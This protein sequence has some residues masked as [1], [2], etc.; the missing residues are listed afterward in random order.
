[1][2]IVPQGQTYIIICDGTNVYSAS[3]SGGGGGGGSSLTLANGA[4]ASPSLNFV[5]DTTTGLYLPASGQL[6]F[7]ISGV[8][9]GTLSSSG[10]LLPV[11]ISGGTF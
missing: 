4:A 3:G 10:L 5:G 2:V 9:A 11:G 6:G 8:N 1:M 7:A